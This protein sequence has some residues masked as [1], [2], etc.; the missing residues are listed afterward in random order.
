MHALVAHGNSILRIEVED[1]KL[2]KRFVEY[3]LHLGGAESFYKIHLKQSTG[4]LP[5]AMTNQ[6][7]MM[8]S[9]KDRDNDSHQEASCAASYTG[10]VVGN[11]HGLGLNNLPQIQ[12]NIE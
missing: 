4:D 3:N 2:G 10:R 11:T 7:G 9:T 6:T 1:W 5:D 12:L 8:F